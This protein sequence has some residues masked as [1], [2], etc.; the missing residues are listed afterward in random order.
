MFL[1]YNVIQ[2]TLRNLWF[3]EDIKGA[4]D[5]KRWHHQLAPMEVKYET[6]FNQV[7]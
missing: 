1:F 7:R 3:E 5:A 6:D 2:V 4:I